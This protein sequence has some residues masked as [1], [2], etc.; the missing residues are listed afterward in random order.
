[1]CCRHSGSAR[2]FAVDVTIIAPLGPRCCWAFWSEV[3]EPILYEYTRALA[4]VLAED[5][6]LPALTPCHALAR[7]GWEGLRVELQRER[8]ES[9]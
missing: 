6:L 1:L 2:A 5:K 8:I 7:W 9:R 4:L 3:K